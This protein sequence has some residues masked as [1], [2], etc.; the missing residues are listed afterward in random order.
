MLSVLTTFAQDYTTYSYNTD[1]SS[2]SSSGISLFMI[3]FYL[4][5]AAL[6]LVSKW[7]I[8]QKA[9]QPGWAAIVPIY[10]FIVLLRIV[11][12]PWWW[13]FL[14]FIPFAGIV[15]AIIVIN[16]LAKSFGKDVGWTL[17]L[18]FVSIVGYPMLAFGDA[19]YVGPAGLKGGDKPAAPATPAV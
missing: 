16:D 18:L 1:L 15:F 11:G 4:A 9:G 8:Y 6:I 7:K 17:L 3:L 19:K 14:M 13:L 12:R 5:V 10:D 2:G